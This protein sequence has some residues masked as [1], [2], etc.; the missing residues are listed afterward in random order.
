MFETSGSSPW[1]YFR[2]PAP[3]STEKGKTTSLWHLAPRHT[4]VTKADSL[5]QK[6]TNDLTKR[7]WILPF[8]K[9]S[10]SHS[11]QQRESWTRQLDARP[12]KWIAQQTILTPQ[13]SVLY[14]SVLLQRAFPRPV[15]LFVTFCVT[16]EWFTGWFLNTSLDVKFWWR[17]LHHCPFKPPQN[18]VHIPQCFTKTLSQTADYTNNVGVTYLYIHTGLELMLLLLLF[19]RSDTNTFLWHT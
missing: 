13:A 11:N 2:A 4:E 19:I 16:D 5:E 8:C 18:I 3:L 14:F 12:V 7:S 10:S 6:R 15:Q 17:N 1:D 9:W